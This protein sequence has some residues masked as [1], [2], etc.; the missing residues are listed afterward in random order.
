METVL[1][2]VPKDVAKSARAIANLTGRS[3]GDVVGDA[4]NVYFENEAENL[5]DDLEQKV[6]SLRQGK[7]PAL[8]GH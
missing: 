1:I 7:V 8:A 3:V 5:A 6:K 2:R 4:W